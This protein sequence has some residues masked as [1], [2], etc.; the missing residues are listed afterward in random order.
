MTAAVGVIF[1]AY[2]GLFGLIKGWS[3]VKAFIR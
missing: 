3:L 1:A 2:L